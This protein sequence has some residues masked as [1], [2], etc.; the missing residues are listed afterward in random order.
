MARPFGAVRRNDQI[1]TG[2]AEPDQFPERF[3]ASPGTRPPDGPQAESG[4]DPLNQFPVAVP[5]DEHKGFRAAVGQRH[6][7]LL[8]VPERDDHLL[9]LSQQGIHVVRPFHPNPDA[10]TQ[11]A[12]RPVADRRQAGEFDLRKQRFHNV[13]S[14]RPG[15][16]ACGV[17]HEHEKS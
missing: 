12:N 10:A 17:W 7:Q 16:R 1:H 8:R 14:R 2:P 6:H 9:A 3:G 4:D 15:D 11:E 5:A 13:V